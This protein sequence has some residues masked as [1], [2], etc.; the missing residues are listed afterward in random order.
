M[1]SGPTC[2]RRAYPAAVP[3]SCA[4]TSRHARL[5]YSTTRI[6]RLF[7][8]AG[9]LYVYSAVVRDVHDGDTI[10][11]DA[12]LG[13]DVWRHT[14]HVRIAGISA[15]EL[16]MPGGPEARDYLTGLLPIDAAVVTIRSIKAEHDPADAMS[17]DRYVIVV[18]L[19]DGR[20]LASLLISEGWAAPWDGKTRPV[21]YPA[22]P[23]PVAG[24]HRT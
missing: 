15:R 14:A 9:A 16:S 21:P 13:F 7:E 11:V 5:P 12:D 10:S 6:V 4:T 8:G 18:T 19:A 20:D 23:I 1:A 22:W 3:V 24:R 2:R 17:F